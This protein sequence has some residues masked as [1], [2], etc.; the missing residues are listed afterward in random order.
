MIFYIVVILIC[1]GKNTYQSQLS[2]S[3]VRKYYLISLRGG[4]CEECGYNKNISAIDFH[5]TD[6]NSK[7]F[8]LSQK[9]LGNYSMKLILNEF[10][11]CKIL[12][13]NC[14]REYHHPQYNIESVE[15]KIENFSEK[16]NFWIK[17]EE[18]KHYYCED[19]KIEISKWGKKCGKCYHKSRRKIERPDIET[20]QQ[21]VKE[22]GYCGAGRKYDVCDNTIRKWIKMAA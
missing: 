13:A 6:P 10:N 22:L 5:H 14:H 7:L 17:D 11:K 12:C 16:I 18:E 20:L 3:L 8:V 2:R 9:S 19:C 1:M 21:E 4:K 15:N